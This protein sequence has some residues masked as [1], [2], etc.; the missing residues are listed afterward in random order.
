MSKV[1]LAALHW[2]LGHAARCVKVAQL[3][4]E[5]GH[6]VVIASDGEAGELLV[7]ELTGCCY[8]ELPSYDI[9]YPRHLHYLYW[10]SRYPGLKKVIEA[11]RYAVS[12]VVKAHR[13]D[14]VISDNRFGVWHPNTRNI[15]L[16]HQ[17]RVPLPGFF[18]LPVNRILKNWI[19]AFD[20]CWIPDWQGADNLSGKLSDVSLKIPLR[21]IGVLSRFESLELATD[22][23]LCV[24][25]SGPE[26]HRR[27]L[28]DALSIRLRHTDLHIHWVGRQGEIGHLKGDNI[29]AGES[30]IYG[31]TLNEILC[32]SAIVIGRSGYSSLMDYYV[33][34]RKAI[35]IATP[36]QPEQLYL[37]RRHGQRPEFEMLDAD[38]RH[39]DRALQR[40]RGVKPAL[41]CRAPQDVKLL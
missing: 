5:Q 10:L 2:G 20:E 21:Y 13:I 37:A 35:L 6:E 16:G 32:R 26:P 31:R 12:A 24:V 29:A 18:D 1:L 8:V 3:L 23:D 25:L 7:K 27:L 39:L 15:Y 22:G 14:T 40:L 28:A 36:G 9:R 30:L 34:N 19:E 41:N 17:L 11:E 38:L 4:I 33:L